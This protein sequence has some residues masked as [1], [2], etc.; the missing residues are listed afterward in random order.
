VGGS[1]RGS[2]MDG[3]RT[4]AQEEMRRPAHAP[5]AMAPKCLLI[6]DC[7]LS[8][9]DM[10]VA[11]IYIHVILRTARLCKNKYTDTCMCRCCAVLRYARLQCC[12]CMCRGVENLKVPSLPVPL[13]ETFIFFY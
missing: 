4:R 10:A 2:S 11:Y 6:A 9:F 5:M 13:F 12:R 1:G 7:R 3:G 8:T